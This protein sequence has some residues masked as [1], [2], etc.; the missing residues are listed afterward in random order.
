[1]QKVWIACLEDCELLE[2]DGTARYSHKAGTVAE[3][4]E[5]QADRW[6]KRRKA[7]KHASKKAAQLDLR[8]RRAGID[9]GLAPDEDKDPEDK[10]PGD[11]DRRED[12]NGDGEPGTEDD[13]KA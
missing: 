13:E 7:T 8:A 11:E 12:M 9:T 5:D 10:D 6:V 4:T 1:M 2:V 3:L